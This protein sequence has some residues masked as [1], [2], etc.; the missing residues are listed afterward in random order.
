M[1]QSC[2]VTGLV[3]QFGENSAGAFA[4]HQELPVDETSETVINVKCAVN[5]EAEKENNHSPNTQ[6]PH[7]IISASKLMV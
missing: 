2:D 6:T 7:Q 4:N 1:H 5:Q 3:N